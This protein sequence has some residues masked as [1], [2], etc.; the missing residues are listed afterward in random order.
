MSVCLSG[1]TGLPSFDA[2]GEPATLAQRWLTWKEEFDLYVT[3]SGISNSTQKRALLLH[4]AGPKVRDIFN[5]SI[6]EEIRG[7]AK[8][9][10]KAMDALSEH[11]KMRKNV[12]MAR[13]AF[14]AAKPLVGETINNFISRLQTLAEHCDYEG[15]RDNQVRDHATSY[16]KDKNL[17][18]KLYREETLTLGKLMEI[19]GHYHDKEALILLSVN[20]VSQGDRKTKGKCWR[21]DK[22]G[23]YA[24]EC[25]ISRDHKCTKCGKVRHLE[26][27]CYSTSQRGRGVNRRGACGRG[28]SRGRGGQTQRD[29]VRQLGE[30]AEK[31][32]S[33]SDFYVFSADDANEGNVLKLKI[34]DKIIIIIIDSGASCNLISEQIFNQI[35]GG[36]VD[37]SAC[38]KK[39]FAYAAT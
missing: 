32:G 36:K 37:L 25:R 27:C 38:H 28:K 11:F 30:E 26:L 39:V 1:L 9:Y 24:K 17:K 29:Y 20:R 23:H 31:Q 6:P 15:E 4:L 21:C 7:D 16:I 33:N 10:K 35:A 5:N 22:A 12:P 3:A 18:S 13:Q 14:I 8:D 19:V 34:E 2:V